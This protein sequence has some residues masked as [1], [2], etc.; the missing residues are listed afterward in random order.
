MSQY[1]NRS[2]NDPRPN[3]IQVLINKSF[4]IRYAHDP[5]QNNLIQCPNTVIVVKMICDWIQSKSR[6]TNNPSSNTQIILYPLCTQSTTKQSNPVSQYSNGS[7]NDLRPNPIQVLIH[8]SFCIHY[9]HNPRQNNL[10][11]CPNT[12]IVVKMIPDQIQSESQ[13]TKCSVSAMH[14]IRDTI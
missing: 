7:K 5:R 6:Y 11:R 9:V 1:S 3:P 12:V 4:C 2:K 8:K 10:I 14:T 13:Y